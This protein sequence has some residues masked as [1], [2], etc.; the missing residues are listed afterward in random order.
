MGPHLQGKA[1]GMGRGREDSNAVTTGQS[2]L[3]PGRALK[4][5]DPL[6]P[7]QVRVSG[8]GCYSPTLTGHW[9]WADLG[10]GVTLDA[11]TVFSQGNFYRGLTAES[12]QLTTFQQLVESVL[13]S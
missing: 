1:A 5:D 6:K 9:M 8:S 3:I 10:R 7:S 11:R 2:Q 4:L 12:Y 13:R